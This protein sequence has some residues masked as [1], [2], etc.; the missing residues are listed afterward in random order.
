VVVASSRNWAHYTHVL[1]GGATFLLFY[2]MLYRFALIPRALA[3]IGVI[4]VV[5]QMTT[6]AMP[7]FGHSVVMLML[8]PMGLSHLALALWLVTKGFEE[9]RPIRPETL[10]AELPR[11]A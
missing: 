9:R 11:R 6:V 5:L 2:S 1:V 8:A 4:A 10:G 7:F 3:A